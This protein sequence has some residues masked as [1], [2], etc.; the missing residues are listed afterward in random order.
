[1]VK[2]TGPGLA[3]GAS[4][5]LAGTLIYTNW[6]GRAY[7]K[8][9]ARPKQPRTGGQRAMR[10]T[11]QFLSPAWS[12][13]SDVLQQTWADL[14]AQSEISPFNAYQG[15]NLARWRSRQPP[16]SEY[17]PPETGSGGSCQN[18]TA[19]QQGLAVSLE[20]DPLTLMQNWGYLVYANQTSYGPR[21]WHQ[22]ILM[23]YGTT[24]DHQNHLWYPPN[25][26]AWYF[27]LDSF[28]ITGYHTQTAYQ[29]YV[30]FQP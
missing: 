25:S 19:T 11:M 18:F 10:A 9:H 1:M 17:P 20:W 4:G 16:S 27:Q 24:T 28:S 26:G 6:K 8:K 22:L 30:N 12:T 21:P 2:L 3:K 23:P 29:A 5:T 13:L 7:L 14:A 15:Y